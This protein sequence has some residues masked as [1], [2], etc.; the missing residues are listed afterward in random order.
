MR[1]RDSTP[2]F[3]RGF[4]PTA[5]GYFIGSADA[6]YEAIR[7]STTDVAVIAR[8][9]GIKPVNIRKVKNHLFYAAHLLDRYVAVGV[10]AELRRFDSDLGIANAWKRLEQG[11]FMEADLQLLRHEAAEAYLMRNLQ[12]PSYTRA[13]TRAQQRFPAPNL[14]DSP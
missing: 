2:I 6:A 7:R 1:V 10:P 13:H 5:G 8:H 3:A 4:Q 12:D 11:T 14:K 9:T